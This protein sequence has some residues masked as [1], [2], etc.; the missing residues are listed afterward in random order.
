MWYLFYDQVS[1][2]GGFMSYVFVL[3]DHTG[4]VK[5]YQDTEPVIILNF[6]MLDKPYIGNTA[7][8]ETTL[9]MNCSLVY[10][11]HFCLS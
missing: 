3:L 11:E 5:H 9:R 2:Y 7:E 4:S 10:D 1:Q 6:Y 8:S